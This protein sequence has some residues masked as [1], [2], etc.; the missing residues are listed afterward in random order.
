MPERFCISF[1]VAK[2][3]ENLNEMKRIFND[4]LGIPRGKSFV[5]E[6]DFLMLRNRKVGLFF[7]DYADEEIDY[8]EVLIGFPY[9]LFHK[10]SFDREVKALSQFVDFCFGLSNEILYAWHGKL[11]HG[12]A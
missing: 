7:Y 12:P 5:G 3:E 1:L 6:S 11:P 9:Q 8:I 10:E 2:S 4:E